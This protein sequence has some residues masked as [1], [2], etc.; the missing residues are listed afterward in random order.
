MSPNLQF[1]ADLVTFTEETLNAKLQFLWSVQGKALCFMIVCSYHVTYPFQGEFTLF[2]C[3]NVKELFARNRPDI[4]RL[5]DY[6]E[7]SIILHSHNHL[8]RK[9]TR[10]HWASLAKWLSVCLWTK[11]VGF[12]S[13]AV[14]LCDIK[15]IY[16]F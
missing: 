9:Q 4:C 12:S 7:I 14:T 3:L 5:C 10:N 6:N 1:P 2:S 8:D 16:Q 15:L 13:V 11:W